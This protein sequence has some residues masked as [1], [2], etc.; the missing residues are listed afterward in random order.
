MSGFMAKLT[1]RAVHILEG[2]DAIKLLQGI[3]TNDIEKFVSS[4]QAGLFALFLDPKGRIL[5]DG[6]ISKISQFDKTKPV[7][8][9]DVHKAHKEFLEA[10]IQRYAFRKDATLHCLDEDMEV[11]AT[12]S[13]IILPEEKEGTRQKWEDLDE[14]LLPKDDEDTLN[15]HGY[16]AF[17]DP[18]NKVLGTRTIS[19][20]EV[21]EIDE[22][23]IKKDANFYNA[24]R[25]LAGICEG[26]DTVNHIPHMLNF[27]LL[28]AISFNK[29]CYV[30]QELIARTHTQGILRTITI[31]FIA[32]SNLENFDQSLFVPISLYESNDYMVKQGEKILDIEGKTIGQVISCNKNIGLAKV[33]IESS[34][35]KALF[36]D[37]VSLNLFKPLWLSEVYSDD[38]DGNRRIE[39]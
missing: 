22:N 24:F 27:H 4:S 36:A 14:Q 37:G 5:C 13:E 3:T 15:I 34:E 1:D 2:K 12:F 16:T 28:N 30:G 17:V 19:A 20:K 18:R 35:G 23:I 31:P 9:I 25:M 6:M 33:K 10:H 7:F 38:K 26:P 32:N 11:Q 21:L 29:G 39:N 8:F